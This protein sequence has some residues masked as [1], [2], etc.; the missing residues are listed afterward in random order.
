MEN[1]WDSSARKVISSGLDNH[2]LT[3]LDSTYSGW[4]QISPNL[5]NQWVPGAHSPSVKWPQHAA[6]H[7]PSSS[8]DIKNV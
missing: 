8:A 4:L 2:S 1:I 7:T 6:D 5:P 3:G